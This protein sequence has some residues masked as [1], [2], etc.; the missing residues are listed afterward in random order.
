[1]FGMTPMSS[2]PQ[3]PERVLGGT[4]IHLDMDADRNGTKPIYGSNEGGIGRIHSESGLIDEINIASKNTNRRFKKETSFL[5]QI[6]EVIKNS[7]QSSGLSYGE[8]EANNGLAVEASKF[9]RKKYGKN[10]IIKFI[11]SGKIQA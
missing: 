5:K 8:M 10:W 4:L 9:M 11:K 3:S 6:Y 7:A 2:N 1:M